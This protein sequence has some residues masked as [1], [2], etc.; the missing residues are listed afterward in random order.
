MSNNT[1]IEYGIFDD[2]GNRYGMIYHDK[3]NLMDALYD[4][5]KDMPHLSLSIKERVVTYGDWN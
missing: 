4:W 5:Q 3:G 1:S 2:K